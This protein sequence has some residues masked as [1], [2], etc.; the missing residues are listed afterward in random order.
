MGERRSGTRERIQ[1]VAVELVGAPL[2]HEEGHVQPGL[3][4]ASA[5]VT[6]GTAGAEYEDAHGNLRQL[7]S[8]TPR[9]SSHS[10]RA[11]STATKPS[12]SV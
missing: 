10:A 7:R 8:P 3:G 2:A 11:A 5:E 1:A 9:R 4:Q 12:I 6:A